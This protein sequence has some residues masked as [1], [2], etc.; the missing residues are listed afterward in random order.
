MLISITVN[1][2]SAVIGFIIK[3]LKENYGS[4][5]IMLKSLL[6]YNKKIRFSMSYL[7]RI[8]IDNKY[9]LISGRR[10]SQY[11]PVGGVYKYYKGFENEFD[12]FEV[13]NDEG[14]TFDDSIKND[15]RIR[16]KG[17]Y[18]LKF[19]KWYKSRT[20]REVSVH[21]EFIEELVKPGYL[22]ADVMDDFKPRFIK[23]IDNK[24]KWSQHFECKELLM[25]D[26][27]DVE[28]NKK[29]VSQLKTAVAEHSSELVLATEKEIKRLS[30]DQ[31]GKSMK[32]GK[33][34]KN[35]I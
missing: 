28:L 6:S 16:L 26:I 8:K 19:L 15:L 2:I 23:T 30:I 32:I 24:I 27:F 31:K 7:F 13:I 22:T 18:T 20:N 4:Y 14:F 10:I 33:H 3:S 35:V 11:Q 9:L 17:K 1:L 5:V 21:R 29:Y 12:K 34:S 25:Y